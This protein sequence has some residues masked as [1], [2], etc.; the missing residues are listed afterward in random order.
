MR[1]LH[2]RLSLA[3]SGLFIV[4]YSADLALGTPGLNLDPKIS[5]PSRAEKGAWKTKSQSVFDPVTRSL[6]RRL[7]TVWD[8][9]PSRDLDFS[10]TPDDLAKDKP[11]RISGTGHLV[12]QFRD[13]PNYDRASIRT[14][15]RGELRDGRLN[16]HGV[17]LDYT[18]LLYE[19]EWH[20]G[21][22]AFGRVSQW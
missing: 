14:E 22:S 15:Y 20:S 3:L 10:W 17:Y 1:Q 13:K 6:S 16:G 18:G 5:G 4:L 2:C 8:A 7:Y 12:W 21:A 19:G 11:G 9:E